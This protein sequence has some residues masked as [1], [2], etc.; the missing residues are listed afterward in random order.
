M[1]RFLLAGLLLLIGCDSDGAKFAEGD[2]VTIEGT[3]ERDTASRRHDFDLT[4]AGTVDIELVQVTAQNAVTGEPFGNPQLAVSL[5]QPSGVT[6]AL[7]LTN[8]L[9]EGES[10]AVFLSAGPYC[11]VVLRT[12][13]LPETAIVDYTVTVVPAF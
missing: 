8:L 12:S 4:D 5:G 13:F 11:L 3:L 2:T 1:T 10:F 7:T 6:C 9:Q